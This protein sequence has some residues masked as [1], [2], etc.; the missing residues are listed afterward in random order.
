MAPPSANY[1]WTRVSYALKSGPRTL[2]GYFPVK[3][4]GR[5]SGT[6]WICPCGPVSFTCLFPSNATACNSVQGQKE[7]TFHVSAL[8]SAPA[9]VH[10]KEVSSFR[11][12]TAVTR[13]AS[14]CY[15]YS[16]VTVEPQASGQVQKRLCMSVPQ[17]PVTQNWTFYI[18]RTP[19]Y[20]S[21]GF[22]ARAS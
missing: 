3:S 11:V 4:S 8:I 13:T 2:V 18:P 10:H 14:N 5:Q 17:E 7:L 15:S 21:D 20:W 1:C 16:A 6:L 12:S 22:F 9:P 19:S